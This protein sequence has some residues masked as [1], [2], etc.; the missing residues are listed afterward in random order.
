MEQR[1]AP[2]DSK[3]VS[4]SSSS[5]SLLNLEKHRKPSTR[6]KMLETADGSVK[7]FHSDIAA[8]GLGISLADAAHPTTGWVG[9]LAPPC[10]SKLILP[11]SST[12]HKLHPA[13]EF[14][15]LIDAEELYEVSLPDTLPGPATLSGV[16]GAAEMGCWRAPPPSSF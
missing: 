4:E 3:S 16:R 2:D 6:V 10:A 5:V 7:S 11:K 1:N 8:T 15:Q 13:P 14:L 9:Q 12:R